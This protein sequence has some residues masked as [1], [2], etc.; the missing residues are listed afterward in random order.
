MAC[1]RHLISLI[2][3][4][5]AALGA[6]A[7]I[8]TDQVLTIGRNALYFEDYLLSIQYFN[9]VI[10]A[11]PYM[12]E[13]YFYRA[14]AKLN[15]ED[16]QGAEDDCTLALDRNPFKAEAYPVRGVARQT[17]H[18]DKE[19]ITDYNKALEIMPENQSVLM[20][21]AVCEENLKDYEA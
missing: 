13:P 6:F 16:Y 8:N 7:Q 5:G 19:A 9:R 15:L 3:L 10:D 11:K 18:K 14:I 4:V 21:K 20:N 2:A 17:L 1:L 12:A